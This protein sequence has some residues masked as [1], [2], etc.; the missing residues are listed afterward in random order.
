MCTE[1]F[2]SLGG[3]EKLSVGATA[4]SGLMGAAGSFQESKL[5]GANA[6]MAGMAAQHERARGQEEARRIRE[7]TR[8]VVGAQRAGMA[9]QGVSVDSGSALALQEE[10]AYQGEMDVNTALHNAALSA[11]GYEQEAANMS[12]AAKMAK[13]TAFSQMLA[14]AAATY[15]AYKGY[16]GD[17][18]PPAD[19]P[20]FPRNRPRA[21]ATKPTTF[22]PAGTGGA[23]F[24]RRSPAH[25]AGW[26]KGPFG[27]YIYIGKK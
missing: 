10:T 21:D 17:T 19:P 6:K 1:A 5:Y 13:Q 14:G 26:V 4:V 22:P 12:F 16:A 25:L 11:W 23:R 20:A 8:Q 24:P 27:N 18:T 15:D 3:M 9:G 2:K 7:M